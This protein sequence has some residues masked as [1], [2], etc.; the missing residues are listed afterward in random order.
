MDNIYQFL[1]GL[2][3]LAVFTGIVGVLLW[4]IISG[5]VSIDYGMKIPR[6]PD[7]YLKWPW[8]SCENLK[9]GIPSDDGEQKD[10][11]VSINRWK[12][13]DRINRN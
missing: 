13:K 2:S 12:E 9:E 11:I 1:F 6:Y 7:N 8:P 5:R 10:N 3:C 4:S